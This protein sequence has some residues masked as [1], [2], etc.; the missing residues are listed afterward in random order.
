MKIMAGIVTFNPSL[1]RL[2]EN[3]SSIAQQVEIVIL[4]DNGSVNIREIKCIVN[5]FSN[6]LLYSLSENNGVAYA[7]NAIL[8]FASENGYIWFITL[9]QDSVVRS[10]LIAYYVKFIAHPDI[11][12]MTCNI[13]DRNFKAEATKEMNGAEYCFVSRCIT[14]GNFVNT[15]I[16]LSM[17]GYDSSMFIDYIDFDICTTALEN[18]YRI[19]KVNYDGL[20]HELGKTESRTILGNTVYIYNHEAT[21][22]YYMA[23]N[24]VYYIKKHM[25]YLGIK[26]IVK[27]AMEILWR[28]ILVLLYEDQKKVKLSNALSGLFDGLRMKVK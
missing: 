14:S 11:A 21:R 2:I 16:L 12:L 13:T 6:V 22:K 4:C 23:K 18:G 20:L 10:D 1:S 25:K 15:S 24:G 7:L 9:D 17:G 5:E 28:I 27:N 3:I 19:L 8:Q 26:G